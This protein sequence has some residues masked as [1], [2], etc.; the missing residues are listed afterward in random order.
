MGYRAPVEGLQ[1]RLADLESE[2]AALRTSPRPTAAERKTSG[3]KRSK[4]SATRRALEK[5]LA[6][7]DEALIAAGC[8]E[9]TPREATH[10]ERSMRI[11]VALVAIG[12]LVASFY[13]VTGSRLQMTS[14][15]W[16]LTAAC[17]AFV[18]VLVMILA[19]ME[20]DN[21]RRGVIERDD[22]SSSSD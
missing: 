18:G 17:S 5:R 2:L 3:K 6:S 20:A 12:L 10:I 13:L 8:R 7:L 22:F 16:L 19:R 21:R 1:R 4:V 14:W 15:S 11:G 9:L